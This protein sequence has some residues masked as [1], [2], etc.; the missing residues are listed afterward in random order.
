MSKITLTRTVLSDQVL[1]L[2]FK[3]F[4][5][6]CGFSAFLAYKKLCR[7]DFPS[8]KKTFFFT[9]LI[10]LKFETL[11]VVNQALISVHVGPEG[12]N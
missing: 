3:L 10:R 9:L 6:I 11:T 5:F 1:N 2:V 7:N 4:V 12:H 8:Q